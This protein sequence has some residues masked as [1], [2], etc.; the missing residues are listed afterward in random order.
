[1][2]GFQVTTVDNFAGLAKA[3]DEAAFRNFGHA[4]A[5][6]R[7]TAAGKIRRSRKPGPIGSPP[8]TRRGQLR[9]AFRF[10]VSREDAIVGPQFS[11]VGEAGSAHE[12]G[13][14]Y[15]GDDFDKRPFMAPSLLENL[16]RISS[17][18]K[19]SIGG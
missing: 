17:D 6:V 1:M 9:R 8:T 14:A 12:F 2:F 5:T 3:K 19:G 16:E 18:W 4:A 15:K 7:K 10:D 13:G 11:I